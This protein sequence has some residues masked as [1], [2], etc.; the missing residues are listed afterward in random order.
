MGGTAPMVAEWMNNFLGNDM[1]FAW[2]IVASAVFSF[3]IALTVPDRRNQS[4]D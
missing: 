4:L 3:L 2:Y 1:A